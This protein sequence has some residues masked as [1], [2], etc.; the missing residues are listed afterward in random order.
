MR[1]AWRDPKTGA[2]DYAKVSLALGG[3]SIMGGIAYWFWQ[4]RKAE[5]EARYERKWRQAKLAIAEVQSAFGMQP[6]G[7]L[8]APT[9]E[10]FER[11]AR[12]NVSP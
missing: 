6:T 8:D 2:V 4:Y 1:S 5:Q 10:L 11:L 7:R 9:R 12:L 3:I